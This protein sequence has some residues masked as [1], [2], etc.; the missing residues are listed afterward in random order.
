M[1][2]KYIEDDEEINYSINI[3]LFGRKKKNKCQFRHEYRLV[4]T[5]APEL[6]TNEFTR[7]K[8]SR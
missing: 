4:A 7:R 3:I 5:F 2:W 1:S 8:I 6:I